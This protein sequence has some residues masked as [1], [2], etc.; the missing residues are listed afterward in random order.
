MANTLVVV[1]V[2]VHVLPQHIEAFRAATLANARES[3]KE[4]GVARFD[5]VQET[6]DPTRFV[7]IE[8]YRGQASAAAHKETAHYKSWRDTVADMMAEPRSS[9]KYVNVTEDA[10]W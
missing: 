4:P 10:A 5:V 7:L 2:N 6:E 1:F 9:K 3:V 8:A